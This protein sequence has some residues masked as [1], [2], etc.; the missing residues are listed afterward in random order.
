MVGDGVVS[1]KPYSS[2]ATEPCPAGATRKPTFGKRKP[3]VT[4]ETDKCDDTTTEPPVNNSKPAVTT[5]ET[6]EDTTAEPP[7]NNNNVET[8]S[9]EPVTITAPT[10]PPTKQPTKAPT[11]PPAKPPTKQP[12][13]TTTTVGKK[14]VASTDNAPPK[15]K[16][17]QSAYFMFMGERRPQ[18]RGVLQC[19][20]APSTPSHV[21][22]P[23]PHS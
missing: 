23:P 9:N 5:V 7:V 2:Q 10:K 13:T 6:D 8:T 14:R 17:G 11:K 3:A 16:R 22:S 21:L 18:L 20:R 4:V 12:T 15:P 1:P 19:T